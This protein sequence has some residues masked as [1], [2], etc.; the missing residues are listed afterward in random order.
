M[1]LLTDAEISSVF[2]KSQEVSYIIHELEEKSILLEI[3]K[4]TKQFKADIEATMERMNFEF[5]LKS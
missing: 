4:Y 5:N 2:H 1:L 3:L